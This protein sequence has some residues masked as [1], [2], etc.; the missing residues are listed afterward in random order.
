MSSATQ[1]ES[2]SNP[3]IPLWSL[4]IIGVNL[5]DSSASEARLLLQG[6]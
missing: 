1:T 3:I 2:K 6:G 4:V 5:I